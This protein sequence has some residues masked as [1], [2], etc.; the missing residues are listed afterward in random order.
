MRQAANND[1]HLSRPPNSCSGII[2]FKYEASGKQM[3]LQYQILTVSSCILLVDLTSILYRKS[4]WRAVSGPVLICMSAAVELGQQFCRFILHSALDVLIP[5][6][7]T[8][9]D[10]APSADLPISAPTRSPT[11]TC[12]V[13]GALLQSRPSTGRWSRWT[14]HANCSVRDL[15]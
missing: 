13:A 7:V 3:T 10:F 11:S 4:C 12:C 14:A 5:G 8:P 2:L 6:G 15:G 1:G 9:C